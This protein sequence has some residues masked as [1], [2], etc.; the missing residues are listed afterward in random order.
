[1]IYARLGEYL[2]PDHVEALLLTAAILEQHEQY[3]LA[4]EAYSRVPADHPSHL[5]AELGRAEALESEGKPDAAL[6]ALKAL[7][8]ANPDQPLGYGV[9]VPRPS[10]FWQTIVAVAQGAALRRGTDGI[11]CVAAEWIK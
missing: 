8:K 3:K 7:T 4:T 2:R 5:A 11:C 10:G 1:M 9:F 6:E